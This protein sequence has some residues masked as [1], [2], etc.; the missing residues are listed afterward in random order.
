VFDRLLAAQ[1]RKDDETG[2]Q[3]DDTSDPMTG[4]KV[5][6]GGTCGASSESLPASRNIKREVET[7][8]SSAVGVMP[9]CHLTRGRVAEIDKR[10]KTSG[11]SQEFEHKVRHLSGGSPDKRKEWNQGTKR[12][13]L[14]SESVLQKLPARGVEKRER[15]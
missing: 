12:V 13:Q 1:G 2:S 9:I 7:T 4:K 10:G 15:R 6:G 11:I 8:R 14:R 3:K 5:D